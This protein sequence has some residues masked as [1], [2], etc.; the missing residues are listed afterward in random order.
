MAYISYNKLWEN[1]FDSIVSKKDK[2]QVMKINQLEFEVYDT[3]E[4][5]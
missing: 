2:V 4:K 1:E 5:D 3:Q